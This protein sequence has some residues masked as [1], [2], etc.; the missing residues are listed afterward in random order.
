M[1][2]SMIVKM[3]TSFQYIW[4][5]KH[6]HYGFQPSSFHFLDFAEIYFQAMAIVEDNLLEAKISIPHHDEPI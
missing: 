1:L 4:Q 5:V 3:S 2:K 6:L